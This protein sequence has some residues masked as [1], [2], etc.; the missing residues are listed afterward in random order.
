ME[1]SGRLAPADR[2]NGRILVVED[3]CDHQPLLMRMLQRAGAE[4]ALAENGRSAVDMAC[5]ARDAGVPFDLIVM[6]LQMPVLDGLAA[7]EELRS[8][9][10]RNPIVA[11]TARAFA[12]DRE[13]S[14]AVG[15]DAFVAKPVVRN[16]FLHLIAKFL[17]GDPAVASALA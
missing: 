1:P 13:R 16:D 4:V 9:G 2:L 15:C 14:F 8:L 17:Q 10:F 11:V 3:D 6:D 12:T 5:A 7:T